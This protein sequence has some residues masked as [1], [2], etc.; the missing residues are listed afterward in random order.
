[1][2]LNLNY[3]FDFNRCLEHLKKIR[4]YT[5]AGRVTQIIGLTIIVQ[6]IKGFVGEVCKILLNGEES[7]AVLAEVVVLSETLI[8]GAPPAE[9]PLM[10][11][12]SSSSKTTLLAL[13]FGVLLLAIL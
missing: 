1:M 7:H 2:E 5:L 10:D 8:E 6:G 9:A 4:P 13:K 12:F 3:E 11:F